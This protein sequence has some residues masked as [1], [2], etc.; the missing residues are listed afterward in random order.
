MTFA[1][2][3][4][5][6]SN[7]CLICRD[8]LNVG[9]FI[10]HITEFSDP[11]TN[12]KIMHIF[13]RICL[14]PWLIGHSY[15]PTCIAPVR[16]TIDFSYVP[17]QIGAVNTDL[18]HAIAARDLA[19]VQTIFQNRPIAPNELDGVVILAASSGQSAILQYFLII[20]DISEH[21]RGSAAALASR[22]GHMDALQLLLRN[23]TISN[24]D[25]LLATALATEFNHPVLVQALLVNV[26]FSP[27]NRGIIARAAARYGRPE[28]IRIVLA[29]G[30]ITDDYRY[31]A[32]GEAGS[33]RNE[34]MIRELLK[35]TPW[36]FAIRC[37]MTAFRYMPL[38]SQISHLAPPV[39]SGVVGGVG[40]VLLEHA[41][42]T[43]NYGLTI[44]NYAGKL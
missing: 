17:V 35:T 18:A 42:K 2:T 14:E 11:V 37:Y 7:D 3:Y 25:R 38:S 12:E 29:D 39:I 6:S 16:A 10:T 4:T 27:E 23:G 13:H 36:P 34:A 8:P 20:S 19:A 5:P 44:L 31:R 9:P 33:N 30:P 22:N 43:A 40:L 1:L 26:V 32:L 24:Y 21:I 41:A 15:C 28:I